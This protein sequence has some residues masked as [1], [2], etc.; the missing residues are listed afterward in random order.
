MILALATQKQWKVHQ[1]DVKSVF[2]NGD[3]L[4]EV[5]VDQPPGIEDLRKP[6]KF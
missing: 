5:Y 2:L 1:F 4:D 3:L 6:T